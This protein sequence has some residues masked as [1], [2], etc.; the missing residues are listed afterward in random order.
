V[1]GGRL[2]RY[3]RLSGQGRAVLG[4]EAERRAAMSGEALRRLAASPGLA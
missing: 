4:A 3:Y 1:V 2:R